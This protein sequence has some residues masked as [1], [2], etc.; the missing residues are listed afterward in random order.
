[1]LAVCLTCPSN[2]D[3]VFMSVDDINHW[4]LLLAAAHVDNVSRAVEFLPHQDLDSFT[5]SLSMHLLA[6]GLSVERIVSL[7]NKAEVM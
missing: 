1:M 5:S 2:V 4:C 6:K 7:I 3:G